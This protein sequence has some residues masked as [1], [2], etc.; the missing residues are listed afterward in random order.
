VSIFVSIFLPLI[1]L[2]MNINKIDDLMSLVGGVMG[3]IIAIVVL[4]MYQKVKSI[5][6]NVSPYNLNLSN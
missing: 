5:K 3:G 2:F 6:Q 4:L 1:F